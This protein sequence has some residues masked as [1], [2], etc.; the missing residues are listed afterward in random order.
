MTRKLY[1][2]DPYLQTFTS[3]VVAQVEIEGKP[4]LICVQTAFY[5]TSG[6]QP[7]DLGT[8][9]G[10]A[11]ID[12][13]EAEAHRIIHLLAQPLPAHQVEGR[14]DWPRRFDH[15]Q[16]HTGQH[17]LSQAFLQVCNAE[18]LSFHLGEEV[19]TIDVNLA[20]IDEATIKAVEAL[21]N[22][23]IYENRAVTVHSVT[24][25]EAQRFPL[26]KV[27]TV[28]EQ[29]RIIEIEDFDFSPC[30]GTH[31]AHTGEIGLIKVKKVETYKGGQRIYFV[32]GRRALS[33]YQTKTTILRQLAEMM[34]CSEFE[35]V[36]NTGKQQ[37]EVKIL[38]RESVNL[39]QQL[40]EYEAQALLIEREKH[41]D[42]YI[43]LKTFVERTPKDLKLLANKVLDH[44]PQT[45]VLFG[46]AAEGK[47]ALVF[48]RSK[49]LTFDMNALMKTACKVINGRGG[50]Q[51]DQAQGGSA[52]VDNLASALQQAKEAIELSA[53][54]RQL[55]VV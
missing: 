44:S 41:G 16:Q 35:L 7:H 43:L 47:A 42:V 25:A 52:E 54:G 21:A 10:V 34:S 13:R 19:C 36:Q 37:E 48:A 49:E 29:I 40:L 3:P 51:P 55:T 27:P 33:D 18:T 32:C 23:I 17:I 22:Q 38:H 9:N 30:G 26:R 12:V 46:G 39:T 6:G 20:E 11:V 45:V 31:C 5:P 1:H 4:G 15:I 28:E 8:L 53:Q 50:G 24:Q 14:I 2:E